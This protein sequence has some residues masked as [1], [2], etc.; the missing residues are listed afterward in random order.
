MN[1]S[2]A[3]LIMHNYPSTSSFDEV[4]IAVSE[5]QQF[6]L[7]EPNET[8]IKAS[9]AAAVAVKNYSNLKPETQARV[10]NIIDLLKNLA[11]EK[12]ENKKRREFY[13]GL[14][15]IFFQLQADIEK[16]ELPSKMPQIPSMEKDRILKSSLPEKNFPIPK[17][18][19]SATAPERLS[20][21]QKNDEEEVKEDQVKKICHFFHLFFEHYVPFYDQ[22]NMPYKRM[23]LAKFDKLFPSFVE[24]VF[25]HEPQEF[26]QVNKQIILISLK[27]L[28]TF[29]HTYNEKL[30]ITKANDQQKSGVSPFLKKVRNCPNFLLI[31]R[32]TWLLRL[33][34]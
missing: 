31:E 7:S 20:T 2:P 3:A 12:L 1:S 18:D 5:I 25:F 21:P 8:T 26:T 4:D 16:S 27:L 24:R 13:I 34:I 33:L 22:G 9:E 28:K 29:M 11:P 10:K 30:S 17:A 19:R 15:K 23:I 32:N 6:L 14:F